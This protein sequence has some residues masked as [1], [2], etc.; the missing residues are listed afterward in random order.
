MPPPPRPR[1]AAPAGY[2]PAIAAGSR[3]TVAAGPGATCRT[4]IVTDLLIFPLVYRSRS[5]FPRLRRGQN[6]DIRAA[7]TRAETRPSSA[8]PVTS[9]RVQA[10]G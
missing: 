9:A 10:G 3:M 2:R 6:P 4:M 8:A 1:P 7:R 5:W